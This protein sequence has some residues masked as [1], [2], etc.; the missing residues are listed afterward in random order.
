MFP[1]CPFHQIT[2]L[3]CP[4][5]GLTRG[6]YQLLHGHV[7]AAL[8]YNLFTPV[9]VVAIAA[10]WLGWLRVAWEVPPMRVP[11]WAGRWLAVTVPILIVVFGVLRNL[12][13]APFRALA[14]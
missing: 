7:A 10:A 11:H 4:G 13:A 1:R 14:P 8:G 2:G 6:I 3:W 12:P 5:C 9:V